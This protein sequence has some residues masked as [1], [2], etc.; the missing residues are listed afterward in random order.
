MT[1]DNR[2]DQ[3]IAGVQPFAKPILEYIREVVHQACPEV[4][5]TIKWGFPH[6][7]YGGG[8]MC[9]MA[10][11]KKY[12]VFGFWKAP[13]LE[14]PSGKLTKEDAMGN[15]GELTSIK[16]LPGKRVLVSLI[17]QSMKLNEQGIKVPKMPSKS[18]QIKEPP[19]DLAAALKKNKQAQKHFEMFPPSAKREYILWLEDAKTEATRNRRLE[20]AI[21]WISEGKKRNWKYEKK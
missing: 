7:D 12:A 17:K 8:P 4:V 13:L 5:E 20:T 2:I 10:A 6:F 18:A 16:D 14:D 1:K 19:A 11:F 9:S 3:Y 15:F 21:E